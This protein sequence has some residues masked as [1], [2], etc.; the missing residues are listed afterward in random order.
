MSKNIVAFDVETTGL[1]FTTDYIIQIAAVKFDTDFNI[2]D[3]MKHLVKPIKE[4]EIAPGALEKHGITK[5]FILE[6]GE[7]F[8]TIAEKFTEFIDGCD[9]LSYNGKNFDV[10]MISK[11][12]ASVG[13]RF[14]IDRVFYDSMLLE[15]ILNPR[16]LAATYKRYTGEV[17]V[18]AHDA[19]ADVLATIEVFKHQV[20]LFESNDCTLDDIMQLEESRIF[21]V[22]G[23]IK[24]DGD[25]IL[26]A[27]GKYKD[28]EF[29][30][31][32]KKDVSYIKWFMTNPE[33]DYHTK[34]TLREYYAKRK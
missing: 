1:S 11:D 34:Q 16:T 2:I 25:N 30:E 6:N 19:L 14:D 33:F 22:D 18:D 28:V 24:Q 9:M 27:K 12:F 26:F 15:S 3:K 5:E 17:L 20:D 13:I 8:K 29:M 10:R 4:F 31:V 21:C 7:D 23:M 32:A